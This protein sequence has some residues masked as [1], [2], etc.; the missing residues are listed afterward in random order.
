MRK[1]LFFICMLFFPLSFNLVLASSVNVSMS[2]SNEIDA[3]SKFDIVVSMN[4]SDIWAATM[5]F[6]YDSSKLELVSYEGKNGFNAMIGK[7]IVVDAASSHNG[8][9]DFLVLHFKAKS[10][11]S[12]GQSTMIKISNVEAGNSEIL[13][14]GNDVSKTIKIS[15]PKSSDNKLTDLKIDDNTIS[16]FDSNTT[17]YSYTTDKDSINISAVLSDNKAKLSGDGLKKLSYGD[18]VI[19]ISVTAEN[20]SVRNY[21]INVHRNDYRSSNNYLDSLE[22][23]GVKIKFNKDNL[24]YSVNVKN[25]INSIEIIAKASDSKARV[26]GV[27]IKKLNVYSNSFVVEVVAENDEVRKYVIKIN[28]ED[29]NGNLG[30]LSGNNKLK[31]LVIEGYD[32]GFD[33]NKNSYYLEVDNNISSVKINA[34]VDDKKSLLEMDDIDKLN[35]GS[36][37]VTIKVIAEN[38]DENI[39]TINIVRKD[40]SPSVS[41]DKLKDIID[42]LSISKVIIEIRD[43][44]NLIDD[45]LTSKLKNKKID[46]V[47]NKYN[48]NKLIYSWDIKS[49]NII[50]N[51]IFDTEIKFISDVKDE[52]DKLTNFS[53]GIYLNFKYSG[54]LP[55]DTLVTVNVDDLYDDGDK[56]NLYYYDNKNNKIVLINEDLLVKNG[57]Y[58][59]FNIDHCSDYFLSKAIVG[60]KTN[61]IML[62]LSVIEGIIIVI[63]IGFIIYKFNNKNL[64]KSNNNI[65]NEGIVSDNIISEDIISDNIISDDI[66]NNDIVS[67]NN[68]DNH[69]DQVNDVNVVENSMNQVDI[70]N[71]LEDSRE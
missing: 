8:K 57:G 44:N 45:K 18:N 41:I 12:P 63:L 3:G 50:D 62:I 20:G 47:V 28:R 7:R 17:N 49:N 30:E 59:S 10:D 60:T 39:Y 23:K 68:V 15:I 69:I 13:L 55:K 16:S 35:V 1:L 61:N 14:N 43:D 54:D 64:S 53:N 19:M 46:F 33:K 21:K 4:G 34:I 9:F 32:I 22:I 48:N 65:M 27:G 38:G 51:F 31:E 66:V 67:M 42:D 37:Q 36:N 58:V 2:G 40:N 26:N 5:D 11:F 24:N 56:I 25:N 29:E 70:I 52:I 6:S 71:T